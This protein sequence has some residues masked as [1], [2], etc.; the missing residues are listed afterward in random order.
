MVSFWLMESLPSVSMDRSTK[1]KK[2]IRSVPISI[3]DSQDH[4]ICLYECANFEG[5]KMEV[6][7]EDIPSLWSYGFYDRVASIQVSGGTYVNCLWSQHHYCKERL[8]SQMHSLVVVLQV[9]W[10]PVPWLPWLSVPVWVWPLQALE[11]VG[12]QPSPDPIHS[13]SARHA[14][15]STRLFRD[16]CIRDA[17]GTDGQVAGEALWCIKLSL[18]LHKPLQSS[19][20]NLIGLQC[21]IVCYEATAHRTK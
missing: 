15:T 21:E 20:K 3:Q 9:G 18:K 1:K 13:P 8:P 7:D 19:V 12:S 2:K 6:C 17:T 10:V 16:D 4:K 14:D 11:W 5:R